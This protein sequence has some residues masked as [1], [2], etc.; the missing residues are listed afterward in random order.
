MYL[1]KYNNGKPI[2]IAGHSQGS[3]HLVTLLKE[4]FDGKN[5]KKKLIAAYLPGTII[6]ENDFL[7]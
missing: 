6:T 4:F 2:I 5:L 1:K 3:A 7:I